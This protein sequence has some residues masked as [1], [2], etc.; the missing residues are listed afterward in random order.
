MGQGKIC[1]SPPE[2]TVPSRGDGS[3]LFNSISMLLTGK[4]TYSA[5]LRHVVC[6]YI[7]NPVKFPYLRMYIPSNYKT[8]KEYIELSN[9]C[10][11]ITW[12]TEVEIITIAQ[13]SGFDVIVYMEQGDWAHYKSLTVD[14]E[15]IEN[16]FYLSNKSGYHFDPVSNC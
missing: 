4:D 8:G 5:I 10:N 9:M 14:N 16:S 11:Y 7:S 3:C 6:N 2:I 15:A 1:P 12:G 13:L